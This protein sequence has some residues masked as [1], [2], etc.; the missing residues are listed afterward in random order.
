M[1]LFTFSIASVIVLL[2]YGKL[3][4]PNF[5][6]FNVL[7]EAEAILLGTFCLTSIILLIFFPIW[8]LE[9]SGV[10]SYRVYP[11]ERMPI[12]IQGAHSLYL[13]LLLGYAGIST[14]LTLV[15]YIIKI[16]N[17]LPLSDP[18]ILIPIVL[19]ALPFVI[20]GL[21]SLPIFLYERLFQ[22]IH[23]RLLSHLSPSD[24]PAIQ[25][26]TFEEIE[27]PKTYL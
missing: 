8:L 26:P 24:Y 1:S 4:R 25:I 18:A 3:F 19:I 22:R 15:N 14:I 17:I 6:E 10:V 13:H 5:V 7:L 9:D 16:F 23:K 21:F 27:D 11:E 2:G 20:T 12:D